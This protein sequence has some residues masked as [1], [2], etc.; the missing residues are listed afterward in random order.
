M[1][2]KKLLTVACV[3]GILAC[4][5]C[6][7]PPG[8]NGPSYPPPP[9]PSAPQLRT[10]LHGV[11][12]IRVVV[13]DA[14][15]AHFLDASQVA[16]AVSAHLLE[17]ASQSHISLEKGETLQPGDAL[18]RIILQSTTAVPHN[19]VAGNP[20][21]VW[22][23]HLIYTATLT[24]ASGKTV[25]QRKE[26]PYAHMYELQVNDPADVWTTPEVQGRFPNAFGSNVVHEMLYGK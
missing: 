20:A 8:D 7:L 13:D 9:P 15:E 6:F 4:G 23:F 16:R 18:L 12:A 21:R 14:T 19:P 5:A 1:L 22:Q 25:W 24:D 17:Q 11:K 10:E 2:R 3:V 26:Q